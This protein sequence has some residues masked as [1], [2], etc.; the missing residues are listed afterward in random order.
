MR[1]YRKMCSIPGPMIYPRD[2]HKNIDVNAAETRGKWWSSACGSSHSSFSLSVI[3]SL[4]LYF[5]I[6][7]QI[8]QPIL[9]SLAGNGNKEMWIKSR[10]VTS[11]EFLA[12]LFWNFVPFKVV[13]NTH[14]VT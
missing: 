4:R 14:A 3:L 5:F 13:R 11:A 6:A 9:I 12:G 2:I 8:V 1:I 10:I 7:Q